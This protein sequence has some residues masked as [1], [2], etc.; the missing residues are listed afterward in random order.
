MKLS[1]KNANVKILLLYQLMTLIIFAISA[2]TAYSATLTLT[3]TTNKEQYGFKDTV[4]INGTLTWQPI[5]SPV[6]DALVAVEIR[7]SANLPFLFRT[8]PT[9]AITTQNWPIN[10]TQLYPCDSNGNPK[11]TFKRGANLY[12]FFEVKNFDTINAH[13]VTICITLFDSSNTPIGAWYPRTTTLQP[14]TSTAVLFS[15]DKISTIASTGVATIYANAYSNLPKNGGY[16]YCPEKTVTFTITDTTT[17]STYISTFAT[18]VQ[19]NQNTDATTEGTYELTF[20][21]PRS[22]IRI[23][24]YTAYAAA[25]REDQTAT[26]SK[27]FKVILPGDV[28]GDKVVDIYD[29]LKMSAA[30]G[31]KIGDPKYDPKADINNSGKIDIYDALILSS[32]FGEKAL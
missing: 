3:I 21:L 10:F 25:S 9:G 24:N 6:R 28:N 30:F 26:A 29:G 20:K 27:Q 13:T 15:A 22:D 18:S 17:S 19:T 32:H 8:R 23:G 14:N 5:N 31:T 7:D 4:Y 12:I 1:S 16:P 11:Y 2:K